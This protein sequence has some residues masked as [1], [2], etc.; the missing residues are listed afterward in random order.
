MRHGDVGR[1]L[2]LG[3]SWSLLLVELQL[4]EPVWEGIQS[5]RGQATAE[6]HARAQVTQVVLQ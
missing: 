5:I 6:V 1:L 3:G 4:L 2:L